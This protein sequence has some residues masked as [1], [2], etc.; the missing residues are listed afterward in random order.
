M[1]TKLKKVFSILLTLALVIGLNLVLPQTA[2]AASFQ[3]SGCIKDVVINSSGY[4]ESMK[5]AIVPTQSGLATAYGKVAVHSKACAY[6]Y[7]NPYIKDSDWNNVN[8]TYLKNNDGLMRWADGNEFEWTKGPHEVTISFLNNEVDV[9][10]STPK[11]LYIYLWT[12][13]DRWGIYTDGLISHLTVGNGVIKEGSTVVAPTPVASVTT[14]SGTTTEYNDFA[15]AVTAWE[16]ADSGATLTLL[17]DVTTNSTIN[18]IGKT[19]TLDLNGYGILSN[20]SNRVIRV[21]SGAKLTIND[22]TPTKVHYI[23]LKD[24]HAT[25]VSNTGTQSITNGT[26]IVEVSGG[27]IAGGQTA[28]DGPFLYIDDTSTNVVTLYAG[29]IIGNKSTGTG[30]G[31]VYVKGNGSFIMNGG[32]IVYNKTLDGAAVSL[33]GA[34]SGTTQFTMKGGRI[35]YNAATRSGGAVRLEKGSTFTMAGGSITDN[36]A[37][38]TAGAIYWDGDGNSISI[39]LSGSAVIKNNYKGSSEE[40]NIYLYNGQNIT[41]NGSLTDG[42]SIGVTML[43]PGV[44]TRSTGTIKASDYKNSFFS[45]NSVYSVM[46]DG[47]ELKL[48]TH[49]HSFTYSASGATLT[50]TCSNTDGNCT[51]DDGT[52]QHNHAVKLTLSATD[53]SYTGSAYTGASLSDTTAWTGAG[54]I[55]PTIEYAGRGSTSYAKSTTAPTAAGTYTASITAGEEPATANFTISPVALTIDAAT[56]TNRDYD[57]DSTAVTIS[58]VT[59]KDSS[60]NPVALTLDTDYTVTGAMTDVNAGSGKTVNVTVTLKNGNYSL[61]TN[62]TTTTVDII[63]AAAQTIA[64][65][66]DT[67]VYTATSVSESVA[68]KMPSDAGTLSYMAGTAATTG[69]VTVSGF[70]VDENGAVTATLSG[71]AAGDTVTLPVT[72]GSTNYADSGVNVVITLIDKGTQ[73]ITADPV[74]ATYGD[75]DKA[76][77]ATVT[78]PAQGGGAISYAVKDGSGDYIEV[79][80]ETG[81]LTILKVPE[82]GTAI[83]TATAAETPAYAAASTD[84]TVTIEKADAAAATVTANSRNYDGTDQ[85]LVT[86]TGEAVGGE[87][88]YAIGTATEATGTYAKDIPTATDAGTYYVWYKVAGDENHKDT[89]PAYVTSVIRG[90]ISATV[91]FKVANGSWND[92]EGEAATADR[93]VTLTGYEG[94]KLMLTAEQIPAVGEKPAEGYKAGAWDVTPSTEIEITQDTTYTYTYL[95]KETISK[96]V[97]FK[98]VNGSWNDGEGEAATADRTVTLTGYEGDKLKLTAEQIPAVGEKPADGYKAGAWNVT[99]NTETEIKENTTFIYTY[100]EKAG[101][102]ATVTFKVVNGSWNDGEG[103]AATADRTVTLTGKEGDVLKLTADQI[104]AAGEKPADGYKAGAWNVTP[105]TE[106]EIKED[107][108]FIYTYAEKAG[109]SA[110]V[111]FKVVN[112]SWND[113]EGEAATADRIVT[114]TGKE[115]DVLKLTADQIPAVG[116]KPSAGF[117]AGAWN[118][119]PSTEAEIKEN[120]TFIYTYA[121]QDVYTVTVTNDGNGT[122]TATP[123]SGVTGTKVTLAAAPNEGYL[124][125]EW[126]VISGGVTVAENAFLIGSANV[127]I[128]AVFTKEPVVYS[129]VS[130]EGGEHII[131]EGKNTVITVKRDHDDGKTYR[132]FTGAA[133]GGK[134]IAAGN[135]T[136]GEGSLILTLKASYLDTLSVGKHNLTVYFS[137]GSVDTTITVLKPAPVPKTGDNSNPALWL[138]L[139]IL[140]CLCIGGVVF[141]TVRKRG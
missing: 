124:F 2:K 133:M 74:T 63:K 110:T 46:T 111:T 20:G 121:A 28:S 40:N 136:T 14:Y 49:D 91:T 108:T 42:A 70:A 54:L 122:G 75:T 77:S 132:L 53:A 80:A 115:G 103:E 51:L 129:T 87:M 55:V 135:Y 139:M 29:T 25:A 104:P 73:T 39:N 12:R 23:T 15:K 67:L 56:A 1:R 61:A 86:V 127:E 31:A 24:Y 117:K 100:A 95:G 141:R 101:I 112:G 35:A 22:S 92:G 7:T 19:M 68:G 50:A 18:V 109:I 106:V 130:V 26:G 114:L 5:V 13:S 10:S 17:S 97:T 58:A 102:S 37:A 137:D 38:T 90:K 45:D 125:K 81:A 57:K 27:Y 71:G 140:G 94:D 44:F 82:N 84:V 76:V 34:N 118:V 93:T 116:A 16:N 36:R 6:S 72:I 32:S 60:S 69:S 85:P 30:S 96:T 78:D 47:N 41:V 9:N 66:T 99:P 83:V 59:F 52:E 33:W 105:S 65:V 43:N 123:A 120:T 131:G 138:A 21:N 119:T 62:T 134:E 64:D 8:D 3:N 98:V 107:T 126:Q 48:G 88:Q 89:T 113:G 79:N 128:K 11:D 4:L